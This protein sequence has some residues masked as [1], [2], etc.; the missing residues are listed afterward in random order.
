MTQPLLTLKQ[1]LDKIVSLGI[2]VLF[3]QINRGIEKES[4][5][6]SDDGTLANTAHPAALGSPLTH[7]RITTDFSE[8]QLEFVSPV[9][10]DIEG[11]TSFLTAAHHYTY[12]NIGQEKLWV[13]SMPCML[14]GDDDIPIARFGQ[15]NI[16]KMKEVYR[17]G[18]GHRYGRLM[19]TISGIHYNFSLP[20]EFWTYYLGKDLS[21]TE[22]REGISVAY[23]GLI[24]NFH[25][26]AWLVF[27][28]FGASPAVCRTFLKGRDHHLD[29]SDGSF[30]A[31]YATS[32]RMSDV[33]YSNKA[34]SQIKVCYNNLDD[35]I[36]TLKKALATEHTPYADIGTDGGDSWQQLNSNLLQIENEFY[37]VIR[38]KRVVA[39]GEKP[40][41][42]LRERG[43]EYVEVRCMDLN[44]FVPIGIDQETIHF[45]DMFLL[46]CLLSASPDIDD[47]ENEHI[48]NNKSKAVLEGRK[49]GLELS[50]NGQQRSL[51]D[52]GAQL[53][54][55]LRPIAA[56]LDSVQFTNHHNNVL[57]QQLAKIN[58]P[59][60]TPSDQVLATMANNDWSFF[61]FAQ[62]QAEE[63]ERFF[64]HLHL[65][66]S[67]KADFKKMATLSLA[68]QLEI[69]ASDT[70]TFDEFMAEYFAR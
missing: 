18:L 67:T 59:E 4:L 10:Q 41:H 21:K 36:D 16:A 31:P 69:E 66:E 44:P 30:Y 63:H 53:I 27:Y 46:H 9:V 17:L 12:Q 65:N 39:S 38:P 19:Q 24:R 49:P 61:E 15:S 22:L 2:D 40:V 70:Q 1:N 45:L 20:D 42:A 26:H 43:V 52:W 54:D 5:R 64:K 32:L 7:P 58:Q 33:G 35:Y 8:A 50:D 11:I 51:T 34:Q 62:N 55:E 37:A 48:A 56:I 47:T 28:L 29:S 23:F 13:N 6:T 68:E 57:D 3:N 60:L 25:R 14:E